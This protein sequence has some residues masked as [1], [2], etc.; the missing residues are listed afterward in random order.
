MLLVSVSH[1]AV[2]DN[3]SEHLLLVLLRT[4][5]LGKMLVPVMLLSTLPSHHLWVETISAN[6]EST[7]GILGKSSIQM[8][9]STHS[10]E[11]LQLHCG[12]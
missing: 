12:K 1:M 6:Q 5:L 3:T 2:H 4:D 11:E 8:I 9:L 10:S 7:L